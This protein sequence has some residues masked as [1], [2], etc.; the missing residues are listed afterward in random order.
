M[1]IDTHTHLYAEEFKEDRKSLIDAAVAAG[2]EKFYLPNID[3]S[4]ISAMLSLESE[5]PTTCF[6]MMGLHPCSVKGNVTEQLSSVR[7]WL[8]K[9]RFAGIGEIGMDLYWDKTFASE[10]ETAFR[11]QLEWAL[12]FDYPVSIHTR[13]AFDEA[14]SILM[15]MPDRPRGVFHCFSGSEEQ[16]LKILALGNFMLGIGGVLTFKN[17]GLDKVIAR[18]GASH[19]VLE[20]DAPYLAPAPHRGKRNE[21]TWL[22]LVAQKGAEATGLELAEFC[23]ITTGNALRIF[24]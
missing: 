4:S 15:S 11:A 9:R 20:T 16:A 23:K 14:H 17:A 22:S 2:I 8:E 10:Q 13:N 19:L 6:A 24:A 5:Y 7:S 3:E 12:E 21:P 18:I 1:L